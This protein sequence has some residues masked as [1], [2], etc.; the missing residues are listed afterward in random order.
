[1]TRLFNLDFQLIHDSVLL[2]ISVFFLFMLLSYLLFNPARELLENRRKRIAEELASAASDQ[3]EAAKLKA[4]YEAKLASVDSEVDAILAD[5]RKRALASESD[6][7]DEAKQEARRII[8][9]A[10]EEA[11]L[12]QK[13]VADEVKQQMISVAALMA[14]RVVSE[15]IDTNIQEKLV[16]ETLKEMGNVTWQS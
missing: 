10:H 8:D 12:E 15:Q 2:A 13:R 5:A 16:D 1:M 3:E 14:Q 11:R 9:R 4:E 7:I 6:I